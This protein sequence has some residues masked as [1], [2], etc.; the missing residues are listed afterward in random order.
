MQIE[1]NVYDRTLSLRELLCGVVP[2]KLSAALTVLLGAP[3]RIVSSDGCWAMADTPPLA[4]GAKR[5]ALV[6]ELETAGFLETS[7][8]DEER[9]RAVTLI[10][11]SFM[12]SGAR[13]YMAS[14]LHLEVIKADFDELQRRHAALQASEARYRQLAEQLEQRVNEQVSTIASAHR[15]LYQ[16]EKL[17]SV[18]QLAAGVAHEINNPIGFIRS[19][20]GTAAGYVQK[21]QNLSQAVQ[22]GDA[23]RITHVW[24]TAD[25]DFILDDFPVLLQESMDGADRVSRIV[26]DLKDF[27][28]VDQTGDEIVDLNECIRSACNVA[29]N[30]I[31]SR[32]EL[33]LALGELPKIKC[34]VGHLNQVILNLLLNAV[35][36]INERGE[37]S[38]RSRADNEHIVI[39]V[40][41]TGC[42]IPPDLLTRIFDP[43]FT[44]REVGSGTGLGLTVSRDI[45]TAHGG[46]IEVASTLG[47]GTTFTLF[48]PFQAKV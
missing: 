34:R 32:T 35:H 29:A 30:E 8:S 25:I 20:L 24:Q 1:A 15:Q 48:L 6:H 18:G 7:A 40:S 12:R 46:R 31:K 45:V 23:A 28:N 39:E 38:V 10:L 47:A 9:V 22:F 19:N 27:S 44:T 42:G 2:N 36:A 13:Y 43:F 14:Q 33:K 17:A 21:F 11:E 3:V 4:T 26:S 41:D 37:I 5:V 16:T